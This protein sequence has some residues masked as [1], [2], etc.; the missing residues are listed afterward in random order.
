MQLPNNAKYSLITYYHY[1]EAWFIQFTNTYGSGENG[2]K[3]YKNEVQSLPSFNRLKGGVSCS[4]DA[5]GCYGRGR[6]TLLTIR[7]LPI[8]KYPELAISANLWLPVQ[9]YYTIHGV[10][11]A[12][13]I[14]VKTVYPQ[15]HT[16]FLKSF[17]ELCRH[18]PF[19]FC[20]LCDG[21]PAILDYS[22]LSLSTTASQV[23]ELNHLSNPAYCKGHEFIGKVLST[24]RTDRLNELFDKKRPRKPTPSGRKSRV[25]LKVRQE[26]CQKLY[27][28][29][30]CDFIYRMR[31]HSNYDNPDMYLFS[32]QNPQAAVKHYN[33][34]KFLTEAIIAGLETLIERKI[35]PKEMARLQNKFKL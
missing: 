32:S 14:I 9:S 31:V 15:N 13:L 1:V 16:A 5:E 2:V 17:S 11:L 29:S 18:F 6:L 28:T 10:G 19:P 23:A 27:R 33:N 21:G 8:D 30:I 20:G 34:L 4:R 7:K 3:A 25:L 12:T 24:T 22:F 26:I 35:G